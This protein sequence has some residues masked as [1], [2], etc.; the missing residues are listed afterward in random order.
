MFHSRKAVNP[1]HHCLN[2]IQE[3]EKTPLFSKCL[4]NMYYS[5]VAEL[6][7]GVLFIFIMPPCLTARLKTRSMKLGYITR[8]A[9]S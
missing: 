1:I 3:E 9:A 6:C 7:G 2:C 8:S 5:I 4:R